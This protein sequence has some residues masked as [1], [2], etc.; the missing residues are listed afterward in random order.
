MY[1]K[2]LEKY[3]FINISYFLLLGYG[4]R[5]LDGWIDRHGSKDLSTSLCPVP[6][7]NNGFKISNFQYPIAS[8][9]KAFKVMYLCIDYIYTILAK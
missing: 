4:P 5:R 6:K 3:V 8:M 9:V 2:C 7:M 1:G